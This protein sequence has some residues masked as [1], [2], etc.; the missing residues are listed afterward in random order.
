MVEETHHLVAEVQTRRN[1]HVEVLVQTQVGQHVHTEARRVSRH[2]GVP[3]ITVIGD[4]AIVGN[5]QI[6]EIHAHRETEM[7]KLG[8][9]I[10]AVE[11]HV[12][13]LGMHMS[14][15]HHQ[16]HYPCNMS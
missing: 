7:Y 4:K 14:A 16:Q 2:I 11:N 10:G 1:S 15:P 8:V 9:G 12:I 6:L 13:I 3:L 5:G